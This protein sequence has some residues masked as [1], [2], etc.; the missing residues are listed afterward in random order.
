V[1]EYALDE[2]EQPQEFIDKVEYLY[3]HSHEESRDTIRLGDGRVFDRSSA[4]VEVDDGTHFGRV[5]FFRDITEQETREQ[6]FTRQN[7]R[8]EAFASVVSLPL[9]SA[10]PACPGTGSPVLAGAR[11]RVL[12]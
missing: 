4:P 1:L 2:L 12:C 9:T 3:E 8:L 5:W 7:E 10:N 6:E 11:N